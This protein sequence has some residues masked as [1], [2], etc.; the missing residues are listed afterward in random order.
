M[1]LPLVKESETDNLVALCLHQQ[2]RI[3]YL[4]ELSY[5]FLVRYRT[6]YIYA[7]LEKLHTG[8]KIFL[9]GY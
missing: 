7:Q 6:A 3:Y 1:I 4:T 2:D 8:L 9:C 5:M